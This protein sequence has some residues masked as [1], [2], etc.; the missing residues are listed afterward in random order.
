MNELKCPN[1]GALFEVNE[2]HY[3][4]I[5]KQIKN[6]E[7]LKEVEL[8][9]KEFQ[10]EKENAIKWAEANIEKKLLE[11]IN[12]KDLEIAQLKNQVQLTQRQTE[13]ANFY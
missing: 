12:K 9:E 4:S 3:E 10:K 1:C 5:A 11:E 6:N 13:L 2:T 8:K 7:F